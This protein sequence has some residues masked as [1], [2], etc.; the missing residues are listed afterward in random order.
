MF[1][2]YRVRKAFGWNGWRYA[3]PDRECGCGCKDCSQKLTSSCRCK[4]NGC[5][6][7]CTTDRK[8]FAGDI[9]IVQEGHPRLE[10][11][12]SARFAIPDASI[13]SIDE[14]L[15]QKK[16]RKLTMFPEQFEAEGIEGDG[17][18]SSEPERELEGAGV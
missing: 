10:A 4:N 17:D 2:A 7:S 18:P 5:G 13:P 1:V 16:Y 15:K 9:W 8:L 11:M 12:L 14:L 6:C 3:P